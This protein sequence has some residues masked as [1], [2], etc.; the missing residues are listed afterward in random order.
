MARMSPRD[1]ISFARA[2]SV[3]T[4][5]EIGERIYN[6]VAVFEQLWE[7]PPHR[8]VA[9]VSQRLAAEDVADPRDREILVGAIAAEC[10]ALLSRDQ[11]M[12]PNGAVLHGLEVWHPDT[13]LT[14]FF[15]GDRDAYQTVRLL[16]SMLPASAFRLRPGPVIDPTP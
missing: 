11:A 2:W 4:L 10:R 9:T 12:F 6:A 16:I 7:T 13:F 1:Q 8:V 15:Q 5:T 3:R 14:A